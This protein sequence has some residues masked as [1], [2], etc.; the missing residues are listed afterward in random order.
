M[1]N[2]LGTIF[3]VAIVFLVIVKSSAGL[4]WGLLGLFAFACILMLCV[5][6]YKKNREKDTKIEGGKGKIIEEGKENNL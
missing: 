6:V 1:F 5:F 3:L 4:L 2:E